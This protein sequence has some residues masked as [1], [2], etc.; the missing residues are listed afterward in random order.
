MRRLRSCAPTSGCEGPTIGLMSEQIPSGSQEPLKPQVVMMDASDG[1]RAA[2][3]VVLTLGIITA[4]LGAVML[5]WPQ[6]TVRVVAIL[7]G[8]WLIL[9]GIVLLVQAIGARASG[10]MR[11]LLGIAGVLS[12]IIGG[13]CVVNADASVRILVLVVAIGWLAH[14]IAYLVMGIRAKGASDRSVSLF[15][16]IVL[17]ALALLVLFW[18]AAT[19]TV[20]V[21]VVGVGLLLTAALEIAAAMRI[22]K[23]P[24]QGPV[25]IVSAQQ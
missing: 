16:G 21:R 3:N 25:V 22:R 18:P 2:S 6:A 20:L 10:G 13:V 11:V 12:L 5:F 23:M 15:F 19:V 9:A 24:P 8:V 1:S 14:G 17:I 7:F 4:V